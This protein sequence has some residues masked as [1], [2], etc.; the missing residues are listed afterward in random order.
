MAD[1]KDSVH[2]PGPKYVRS[3]AGPS[4]GRPKRRR[5]GTIAVVLRDFGRT[6]NAAVKAALS[7]A[8]PES[9]VYVLFVIGKDEQGAD[10][11]LLAESRDIGDQLTAQVL[12]LCK[13]R[14]PRALNIVVYWGAP[15]DVLTFVAASI[16]PTLVTM[17]HQDDESGP[18]DLAASILRVQGCPV[19]LIP[20]E[21]DD[22]PSETPARDEEPQFSN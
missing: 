11:Q 3:L 16:R 8:L 18:R 4:S 22:V 17:V 15:A 5:G 21:L 7:R 9:V 14:L 12:R 20:D 1:R 6:M 13:G 19:L 10:S 2:L